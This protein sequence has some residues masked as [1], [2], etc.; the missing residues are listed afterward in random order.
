MRFVEYVKTFD[1]NYTYVKDESRDYVHQEGLWHETFQCW[2]LDEQFVYIQKRSA[3]K[4]DFPGLFDI[5]AAGHIL[6]TETVEDGIREVEEELGLAVV[7]SQLRSKGVI[8][9]V[10]ELPNF[11]DYEFANVFL[12]ESTFRAS[13]FSLQV[14]EVASMHSVRKEDLIQLFLQEV[15]TVTCTNIMDEAFTEIRLSD[16]VPHDKTYFEE[17]AYMIG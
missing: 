2:L 14:E 6:A 11:H 5:T 15:D 12:Y 13:D 8:R 4:K 17:I 1:E 10:I 7:L 16:F 3:G 9:D